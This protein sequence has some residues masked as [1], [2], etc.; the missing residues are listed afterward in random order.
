MKRST[1][2]NLVYLSVGLGIAA[3]VAFD[4]FYSDSQNRRMWMPSRLALNAVAFMAVLGYMVVRETQKA[5][6]SILQTI[7]C[8]L[9]ACFLHSGFVVAF[10]QIFAARF[11][12]GLWFFIVL[13][14]FLVVRL[15]VVVLRY[16]GKTA[17][18]ERSMH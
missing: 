8:V 10:P 3:L 6:A 4:A 5:K 16:M 15:M 14:L 1:R 18:A 2:D 11:G 13:E 7:A 17:H 12:A 9:V